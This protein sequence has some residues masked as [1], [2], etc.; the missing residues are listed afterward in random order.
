MKIQSELSA[1]TA[2]RKEAAKGSVVDR[3]RIFDCHRRVILICA[4][5]FAVIGLIST[6]SMTVR[7]IA[8]TKLVAEVPYE[9]KH[10][11]ETIVTEILG[12]AG[13]GDFRVRISDPSKIVEI[14]CSGST[15]EQS[16]KLLTDLI[17][18][19]KY[20]LGEICTE[21]NRLNLQYAE[22]ALQRQSEDLRRAGEN[23]DRF[24]KEHPF[25]R[26]GDST[27]ELTLLRSEFQGRLEQ[28]EAARLAKNRAE[29]DLFQSRPIITM[30]QS[31]QLPTSAAGPSRSLRIFV[32]LLIGLFLGIVIALF[33][34]SHRREWERD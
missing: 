16:L 33:Q 15:P 10:S 22:E 5:S 3:L 31:P 34:N 26:L 28:V 21:R 20:R 29:S 30:L 6:R 25:P 14:S 4:A 18:D 19:L 12:P 13:W 2:T 9:L 1:S 23:L 17:E 24:L 8:T 11:V 27:A 7:Y 32:L